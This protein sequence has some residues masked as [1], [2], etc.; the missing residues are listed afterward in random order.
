M[1]IRKL[2]GLAAAALALA[3]A[4]APSALASNP[5]YDYG[6]FQVKTRT[7]L[8]V[9]VYG[10]SKAEGAA[11]VQWQINGG[12]NQRWR[13]VPINGHHQ[14]RSVNSRQCLTAGLAAGSAVFQSRCSASETQQW[15]VDSTLS[16]D[17][18]NYLVIRNVASSLYLTAPQDPAVYGPRLRVDTLR[19]GNPLQSF[20]LTTSVR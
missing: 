13:F 14:L 16:G 7:G 4:A 1:R 10:A 2:A 6:T 3:G 19:F 8:A 5:D 12:D 9:D 15:D 17:T 11:V 18:L 20:D